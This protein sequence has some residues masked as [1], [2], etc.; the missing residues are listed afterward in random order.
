MGGRNKMTKQFYWHSYEFRFLREIQ[1]RYPKTYQKVGRQLE[2]NGI[3]DHRKSKP[4][5]PPTKEELQAE[6][7]AIL[8]AMPPH[9]IPF[10]K[11]GNPTQWKDIN[12]LKT[13]QCLFESNFTSCPLEK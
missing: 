3:F 10:E 8:A 1:A 12:W 5:N 13:Y 11:M 4:N 9:I 2:A 6:F 7:F